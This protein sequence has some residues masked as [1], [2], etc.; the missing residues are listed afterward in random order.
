MKI[1]STFA[2]EGWFLKQGR[3]LQHERHTAIAYTFLSALFLKRTSTAENHTGFIYEKERA[4]P[5]IC[6]QALPEGRP[7][8]SLYTANLGLRN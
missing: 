2:N 4:F 7:P 6:M 1:W 8:A 5:T 3:T